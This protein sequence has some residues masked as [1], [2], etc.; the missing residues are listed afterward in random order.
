MLYSPESIS[1]IHRWAEDRFY[2]EVEQEENAMN[3]PSEEKKESSGILAKIQ[4]ITRRRMDQL[5]NQYRETGDIPH[6]SEGISRPKKP[7][8]H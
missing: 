1:Y 7:S 8:G 3:N 5:W 4:R 2:D 6:I